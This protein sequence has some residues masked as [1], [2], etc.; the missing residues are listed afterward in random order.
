VLQG[1]VEFVDGDQIVVT[2]GGPA[3]AV[4]PVESIP[5]ATATIIG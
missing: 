3:V 1:V 5:I 4:V 2:M